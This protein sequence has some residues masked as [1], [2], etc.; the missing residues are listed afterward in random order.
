MIFFQEAHVIIGFKKLHNFCCSS[1]LWSFPNIIITKTVGEITWG[2]ELGLSG[3]VLSK[4]LFFFFIK[5]H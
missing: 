1:K 4:S 3:R 2:L 5:V